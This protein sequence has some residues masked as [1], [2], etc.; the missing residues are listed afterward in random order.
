MKGFVYSVTLFS[1]ALDMET[2]VYFTNQELQVAENVTDGNAILPLTRTGAGRTCTYVG[3]LT[4]TRG[5]FS[6][7][8]KE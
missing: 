8:F 6:E 4:Q 2:K 3:K 1:V 7:M 5:H